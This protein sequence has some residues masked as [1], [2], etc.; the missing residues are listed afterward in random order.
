MDK[1]LSMAPFLLLALL[2]LFILPPSSSSYVSFPLTHRDA[3]SS[4]L[5]IQETDPT[6]MPE[7]MP[8]RDFVAAGLAM[9][10]RIEKQRRSRAR[11]KTEPIVGRFS[12]LRE[13]VGDFYLTMAVGSPPQNL[14]FTLDT[15][16]EL[17]WT[18][19]KPCR[20][21][22]TSGGPAFAFN[23]SSS[24]LPVPCASPLCTQSLG[25]SGG[26]S[27]STGICIFQLQYGDGSVDA[28]YVSVDSFHLSGK[29]SKSIVFGCAVINL[30]TVP[31]PTSGI[32]GLN[33]G[34]FSFTSQLL[35]EN[36]TLSNRF[37]YCLPDRFK[38]L[39]SQ[40]TVLFGE[41][42]LPKAK[43][44]MRYTPLVPPYGPLGDLYYFV[45]LEGISVGKRF[46]KANMKQTGLQIGGTIFDSG[47]A[48]TH[49]VRSL[50]V[51]MVAEM[52]RQTEHLHPFSAKGT[53]SD[54]CYRVPLRAKELPK[55]P[56]IT[57]H[58]SGMVGLELGPESVLY[59]A[60]FDDKGIVVCLA[61]ISSQS[62]IPFNIIGNY[63]Q[64]NYWVEYNLES[65]SIGLAK[66]SCV[67]RR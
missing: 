21:C 9:R 34:P 37:A 29:L 54:L 47:T 48:V 18:Q 43:A 13:N 61:F 16:S 39:N 44:A 19:C 6:D 2:P 35:G 26:C 32:M 56:V 31:V 28:G 10:G 64:Q 24:Y 1:K 38:N 25:F 53:A 33:A 27:N 60:G 14:I 65:S 58:F 23:K 40:G 15:G 57:M 8:M 17:T 36:P 66:A 12:Y 41:Y 42:T 7:E 20:V 22:S 62:S 49:L 59:P 3:Q 4:L 50:H 67:T 11:G 55:V 45:K 52:T 51:E 30:D 5:R 46:I 63:Q